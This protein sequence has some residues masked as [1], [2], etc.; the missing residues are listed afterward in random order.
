VGINT[1]VV[2]RLALAI[3]SNL[4]AE[5]VAGH[6]RPSLGVVL[7][8]VLTGLLILRVEPEGPAARASL[9]PADI[10]VGFSSL[11]ELSAA[12]E[13]SDVLVVK[14]LRGD[15]RFRKVASRLRAAAA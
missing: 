5:F 3:P 14:F 8:P 2:G 12:M 11:E 13:S 9:L 6:S 10:L 4:V 7:R 15:Q 1:L